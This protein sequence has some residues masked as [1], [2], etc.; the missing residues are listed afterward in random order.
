MRA[1]NLKK[2][3]LVSSIAV[4]SAVLVACGGGSGSDQPHNN[5]DGGGH[6][7]QTPATNLSGLEQAKELVRTAKLFISDMDAVQNVYKDTNNILLDKQ[8]ERISVSFAVPKV[9]QNYLRKNKKAELTSKDIDK[10][11]KEVLGNDDITL[12]LSDKFKAILANDDTL[13]VNGTLKVISKNEKYDITYHNFKDNLTSTKNSTNIDLSFGFDKIII[14]TGSEKV[15]LKANQNTLTAT[16]TMSKAVTMADGFDLEDAHKQGTTIQKGVVTLSD[17]QLTA[18]DSVITAKEL[19][20]AM[21]D[22]SNKIDGKML[23]RTLPYSLTI[24]GKMKKAQP[25]TDVELILN[26]TA[27]EKDVKNVLQIEKNDKVVEKSGKHVPMTAMLNIKGNVTKKAGTVIPLDFQSSLIRN[28]SADIVLKK[29]V[30]NVEGKEITVTGNASVNDKNEVAVSS[31]TLKQNNAQV[32][33]KTNKNG[34]IVS[35][36]DGKVAD[37]M[38][39]GK[40]Y[41]DIFDTG[42]MITAKF[43]D[44][45]TITF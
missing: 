27:K 15:E 31:L 13:Q 9:V 10:I 17:L 42:S 36:K 22:I 14:G 7:V 21:L 24:D 1:F 6:K 26:L 45:S 11:N 43:K 34:K 44:N 23:T 35:A 38:V 3:T 20:I 19:Q 30:A 40:D 18:N 41:G 12:K 8:Q 29:L 39:N 32:V 25:K 33:L 2:L 28:N 16:G 4:A 5:T 37:I